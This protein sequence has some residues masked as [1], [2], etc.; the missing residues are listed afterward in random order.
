MLAHVS[1]NCGRRIVSENLTGLGS[2][3]ANHVRNLEPA[4][5][6]EF[7]DLFENQEG[8]IQKGFAQCMVDVLLPRSD[9]CDQCYG[10]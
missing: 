7:G 4:G 2:I 8:Q 1:E 6:V 3:Y 10:L 5:G 9:V